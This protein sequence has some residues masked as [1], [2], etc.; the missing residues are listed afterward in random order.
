MQQGNFRPRDAGWKS[1]NGLSWPDGAFVRD[2]RQQK[3][4]KCGFAP[5]CAQWRAGSRRGGVEK[6]PRA[7]EPRWQLPKRGSVH[8]GVPAMP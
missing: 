8:R 3:P 7:E 2:R 4:E 5:A 6:C 1:R